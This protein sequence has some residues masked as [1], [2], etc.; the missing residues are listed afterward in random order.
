M[1]GGKIL[2]TRKQL[3]ILYE[4][5]E[6]YDYV[7]RN[8]NDL[9]RTHGIDF[10]DVKGYNELTDKNKAVYETF[11]IKFFNMWGLSQRKQIMPEAVHWVEDTE[12]LVKENLGENIF[13]VAGGEV[14]SIDKEGNKKLHTKWEN[15]KYK[16]DPKITGNHECYLRFE[17][18][19]GITDDNG[20]ERIEWLHVVNNGMEW[21]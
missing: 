20:D 16:N 13:T 1:F 12:Y 8:T 18:T 2:M 11:I 17:Y 9:L 3:R 5:N 6:L 10:K 19:S 14:Y 15:E 21:Y 7:L 4:V